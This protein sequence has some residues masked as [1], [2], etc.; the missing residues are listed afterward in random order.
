MAKVDALKKDLEDLGVDVHVS[1]TGVSENWG[2]GPT[3]TVI[4]LVIEDLE[5]LEA[6]G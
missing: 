2:K 1:A 5:D 6:E 4:S 3:V